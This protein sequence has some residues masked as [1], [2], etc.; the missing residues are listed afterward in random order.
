MEKFFNMILCDFFQSAGNIQPPTRASDL[1]PAMG[2][3]FDAL[4]ELED[5]ETDLIRLCSPDTAPALLS[6]VSV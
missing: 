5:E 3:L 4:T 1:I 2:E 6:V